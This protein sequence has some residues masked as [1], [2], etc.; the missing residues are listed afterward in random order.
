MAGDDSS[1]A[2]GHPMPWILAMVALG[3]GLAWLISYAIS[4]AC[5]G[6]GATAPGVAELIPG[7]TIRKEFC[8]ALGKNPPWLLL[9]SII[10][11]PSV[12]L[13]WHWRDK[14]RRDDQANALQTQAKDR[15][16]AKLARESAIA[17]RYKAAAELLGKDDALTRITGLFALWDVARESPSHRV[18]VSRTLAAFIRTRAPQEGRVAQ[19]S[20]P[21]AA[22]DAAAPAADTGERERE[23][24]EA[25]ALAP[26]PEIQ[27]A[28]S[29][30][31]DPQWARDDEGD[32][33]LL[34]GKRIVVDVRGANLAGVALVR[35][36]LVGANLHGANLRDAHLE[37]ATL[38]HAQL[39][40][41]YLVG[42]HLE[43]AHLEDAHLERAALNGANLEDA[44][45]ERAL[46]LEAHLESAYLSGAHLEDA[47]LFGAHLERAYLL[48]AHLERAYLLGAHLE[49]A[50]LDDAHLHGADL[51]SA[52]LES[53]YLSGAHL[54]GANLKSAR[55]PR[56]ALE[57][58][59]AQG[60]LNCDKAIVVDEAE[61]ASTAE[62]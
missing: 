19:A 60:A 2:Q 14:K 55:L 31:F 10:A 8:E 32:S 43:G 50:Q 59:R 5:L 25:R 13:T 53:A 38:M 7:V 16:A 45:L 40:G 9:S 29:L 24:G 20:S 61:V 17:T 47:H 4:R 52:N 42:A 57:M 27:T 23:R 51:R 6:L 36:N 46:L 62:S 12:L 56:D 34:D 54:E 21:P 33:W 1:E 37:G 18:T 26:P 44:H 11:G 48:G 15:E 41:A 3:L 28:A 35:A 58:A 22:S 30:V 39:E 49:D